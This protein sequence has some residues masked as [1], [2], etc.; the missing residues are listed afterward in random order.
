MSKVSPIEIRV[1]GSCFSYSCASAP[2]APLETNAINRDLNPTFM[3]PDQ[4]LGRSTAFRVRG[5]NDAFGC[6]ALKVEFGTTRRLP[7]SDRGC[8]SS[9]FSKSPARAATLVKRLNLC[10]PTRFQFQFTKILTAPSGFKPVNLFHSYFNNP[11]PFRV[12]FLS[13]PCCICLLL[14]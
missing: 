7:V 2:T 13:S 4:L 5:V 12:L 11:C 10:R 9:S 14:D 8:L 1:A 6:E 3:T